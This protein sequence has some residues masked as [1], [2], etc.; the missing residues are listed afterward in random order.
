MSLA[1]KVV[2]LFIVA[3]F[4][5]NITGGGYV[6]F[7]SNQF[8]D[9]EVVTQSDTN[10]ELI[11]LVGLSPAEIEEL[12]NQYD[13]FTIIPIYASSPTTDNPTLQESSS[14]DYQIMAI[15]IKLDKPIAG[16]G[17]IPNHH[18]L[19]QIQAYNKGA[20]TVAVVG[21]V[22]NLMVN[23]WGVG[24]ASILTGAIHSWGIHP[25]TQYVNTGVNYYTVSVYATGYRSLSQIQYRYMSAVPLIFMN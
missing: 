7:A 5:V 20:W 9:E 21:S 8:E 10:S 18:F 19:K 16:T 13:D 4:L 2:V 22:L 1:K 14:G 11:D 23:N 15:E 25:F 24:L 3:V 6:A 17:Y 12:N